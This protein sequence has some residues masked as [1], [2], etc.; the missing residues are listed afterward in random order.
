MI[1]RQ[2]E[3]LRQVKEQLLLARLGILQP[4]IN[5]SVPTI[6]YFFTLICISAICGYDDKYA[7]NSC[8]PDWSYDFYLLM[9]KYTYVR[10][11]LNNTTVVPCNVKWFISSSKP[12]IIPMDI[13]YAEYSYGTGIYHTHVDHNY[14]I[15]I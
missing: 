13:F 1:V 2:Q 11:F 15:I 5:V 3:E 8:L 4:L 12:Y 9:E 6:L 14:N 10:Y 7:L